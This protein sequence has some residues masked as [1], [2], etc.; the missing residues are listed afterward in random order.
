MSSKTINPST[1]T[2]VE[3][4]ES[5]PAITAP[6]LQVEHAANNA[7]VVNVLALPELDL[8]HIAEDDQP[9]TKSSTAPAS[10]DAATEMAAHPD[11]DD[12]LGESSEDSLGAQLAQLI[13][14]VTVVEELSRQAR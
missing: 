8:G 6:E 3:F 5:S 13:D 9:H 2:L 10:E 12:P 1:S 14:S 7:D 11:P 4:G